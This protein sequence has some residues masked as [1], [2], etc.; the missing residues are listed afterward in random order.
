MTH[1]VSRLGFVWPGGGSEHDFY[2]FV[3]ATGDVVR[4]FFSCTRV[5]GSGDDDHDLYALHRTARLDWLEEAAKR[6]V[7]LNLDCVY[8]PCTSGSFVLGRKHAEAQLETLTNTVG[9][10]SGSTSLA[11]I[12][13]LQ[14]ANFDRVSVLA[15]YPEPASREFEKFLGEFGINVLRMKWLDAASG[16]DAAVFEPQFIVDHIP[17]VLHSGAQ[18][19][20]IPDT[21][22]PSMFSIEEFEKTAG[23]PVFTANGV[24][25][26]DAYQ[27]MRKG[28]R[29]DGFGTLIS[30][31]L[32]P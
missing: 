32:S 13:A 20:L 14:H 16:W 6:L 23:I 7:S 30:G 18:V 9:V 1:D 25:L 19:L 15:T 28:F 12:K 26:W 11:F 21:A 24:S 17:D 4:I 5:G 2:Q 27:M 22:F 29:A 10:P 31:Q 3:E 8:W